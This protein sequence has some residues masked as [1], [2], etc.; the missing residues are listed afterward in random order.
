MYTTPAKQV[1]NIIIDPINH[2]FGFKNKGLP[3]I[4][5][6]APIVNAPNKI[7]I[8]VRASDVEAL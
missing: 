2:N 1:I 4:N 6:I 3:T 7:P 8:T 5:K